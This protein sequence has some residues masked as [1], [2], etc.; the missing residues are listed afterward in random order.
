VKRRG[1]QEAGAGAS[2]AP[3][4]TGCELDARRAE[5]LRTVAL[6]KEGRLPLR[7]LEVVRF[8]L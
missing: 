1:P 4:L 6:L 2:V 7:V 5:R 8:S 3:E